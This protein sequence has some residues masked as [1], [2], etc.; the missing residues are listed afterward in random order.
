MRPAMIQ[1]SALSGDPRRLAAQEGRQVVA[2]ARRAR[3]AIVALGVAVACDRTRRLA[4]ASRE[5]G[6]VCVPWRIP[7]CV[8][9]S[10][11]WGLPRSFARCVLAR[12]TRRVLAR[13]R[14]RLRAA[15]APWAAPAA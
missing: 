15:A 6:D 9:G 11:P 4:V 13:L 2:E 5:R 7:W 1:V 10:L 12:L 8:P 14:R 3:P